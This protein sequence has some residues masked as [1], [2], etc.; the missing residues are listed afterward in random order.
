M[1]KQMNIT[2]RIIVIALIL[3][4]SSG[5]AIALELGDTLPSSKVK[6]KNVDGKL[7]TLNDVKG[8]KGTLVIFSCNHCPWVIAWEDRI[9]ALGNRY[10][11]QG[12]GVVQVNSNDPSKKEGDGFEG[13]VKRFKE[14]GFKFP[15]VVDETS[16]VARSFGAERTPEFFLFDKMGKLVYHGTIDDN[17]QEPENVK[18][19]Y[20]QDALDALIGGETIEISE[21]KS[22]GCSIKFRE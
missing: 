19:R 4:M 18:K 17:A 21:T 8:D 16:D 10:M 3:G 20:L 22:L 2:I 14:K 15:Y 11:N 6:M 13:M 7:I 1:R 9:V 12:I 5:S